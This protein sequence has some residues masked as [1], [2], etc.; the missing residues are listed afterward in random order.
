MLITGMIM[1]QE[2][3][4]DVQNKKDNLIMVLLLWE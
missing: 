4:M 1:S 2:F 3:L